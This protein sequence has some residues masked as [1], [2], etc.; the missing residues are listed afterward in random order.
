[1]GAL[2]LSNFVLFLTLLHSELAKLYEVLAFLSAI[3]LN[4]DT[5]MFVKNM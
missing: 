3:G 2:Q 4:P 5:C 1:M